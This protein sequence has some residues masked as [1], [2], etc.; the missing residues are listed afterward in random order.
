M[1]YLYK[2]LWNLAR[3]TWLF[4]LLIPIGT[5]LIDRCFFKGTNRR[6]KWTVLILYMSF[7]LCL[8]LAGRTGN[9]KHVINLTPFWTY[10]MLHDAQYRW[11]LLQNIFLFIPLGFFLAWTTKRILWKSVLIGLFTSVGIEATQYFFRLGL[12]E[13]DDVFHNMLGAVI[14]YLY[15]QLLFLLNKKR[16]DQIRKVLNNWTGAIKEPTQRILKHI[17]DWLLQ[18]TYKR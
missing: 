5:L 2:L 11:E 13:F 1:N 7:I 14:G 17:R 12:C 6:W 16:G 3:W 10:S 9:V 18:I 4:A 15:F 8:T